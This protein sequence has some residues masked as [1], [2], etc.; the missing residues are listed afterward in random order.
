MLRGE[1]QDALG[2][3][4]RALA[5][6]GEGINITARLL[7]QLASLR[8][9]RGLLLLH[10][11]RLDQ[12]WHESRRAE[13]DLELLR[14]LLL[15]EEGDYDGALEAHRRALGLANQLDDDGLRAQA[16][17]QIAGVHGRRQQLEEA[18]AHAAK[19]VAI[20]ERLGDRVNL[21]RMRSNLAF[22]YVQTRQFRA[23]LDVGAAAY[24]FFQ[25]VRDPYFAAATG[26]NLAEASF[27]LG[28]LAGAA[29]Y[30][31]EVLA[32]DHRFTTPYAQFT[33]GQIDMAR[34]SYGGAIGNFTASM[35]IAQQN[36]DPYLVAYAQRALGQAYLALSALGSAEQH[37]AGALALFRQLG[38]PGEVT[39]TEQLMADL[40]ATKKRD[41]TQPA[42]A[43][44][45]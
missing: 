10:Q 27:E 4:D 24:A 33:L 20:Y 32:L 23:A 28:D 5:S 7:S 19:A 17:R 16:E 38:I 6:Y 29:R 1:L 2:Y 11:R 25:M 34:Q 9:R 18:V 21:E 13:F 8:Q 26:A 22:I 41:V 30:A 42:P 44:T 43:G 12:S 40:Q 39:A 31:T 36:N 15:D 14:G 37:M 3:P 35:Q 45:S